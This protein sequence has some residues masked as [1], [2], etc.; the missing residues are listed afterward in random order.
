MYLSKLMWPWLLAFV[1]A[2]TSALRHYFWQLDKIHSKTRQL[3]VKTRQLAKPADKT[4]HID[5]TSLQND[6][7]NNSKSKKMRS[8]GRET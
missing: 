1:I 7:L 8:F 4:R 5:V 6:C 2:V 3:L